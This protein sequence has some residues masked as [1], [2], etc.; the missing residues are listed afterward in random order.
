MMHDRIWV[1]GILDLP[2]RLKNTFQMGCFWK[3][4]LM[5]SLLS[6]TLSLTM[7]PWLQWLVQEIA[8]VRKK[9]K[10]DLWVAAVH[11]LTC[12]KMLFNK[13][14]SI[15]QDL[16]QQ[17]EWWFP[18]CTILFFLE[19]LAEESFPCFPHFLGF[20]VLPPYSCTSDFWKVCLC[21]RHSVLGTLR[22]N[23]KLLNSDIMI[24]HLA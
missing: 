6:L 16:C 21:F 24:R 19:E 2:R 8:R 1:V 15:S 3:P 23:S 11:E 4:S 22:D 17:F 7:Q 9:V 5:K 13:N 18:C 20:H 10:W 12:L 14:P